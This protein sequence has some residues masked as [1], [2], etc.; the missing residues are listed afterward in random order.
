MRISER[1]KHLR[2]RSG[3]LVHAAE[4][5]A[6]R[7][8]AGATAR[9]KPVRAKPARGARSGAAQG[10]GRRAA[11]AA[12]PQRSP[13]FFATFGIVGIVFS[14]ILIE[15]TISKYRDDQSKYPAAVAHYHAAQAQYPAALAAYRTALA[16]HVHPV[17]AAPKPPVA[18][19]EPVLNV[20]SF[21]LPVLYLVLSIA[22]F[23]LGYR[24]RKRQGAARGT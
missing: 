3:A 20:S 6:G 1:K 15:V 23:Y 8:D 7:V 21:S 12:R 2:E 13:R 24:V 4:P 16:K 18:P 11:P 9:A 5:A 17:P 14:L 10:T 22:Y 19:Q